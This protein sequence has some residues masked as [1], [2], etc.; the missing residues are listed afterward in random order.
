MNFIEVLKELMLENEVDLK[1]LAKQTDMNLGSLYYY[2]KHNSLPDL[3]CAKKISQYFGCSLDYLFG[4]SENKNIGTIPNRTFIENYEFLLKQ[5]K[6]NN[7]KVCN[8]LGIN[9][10]SIY[11]WKKNK[12]PKTYNLI[13]IAE[14]FDVSV[15][16][17]LGR[18]EY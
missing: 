10:N 16:Y 14:Y 15:D 4:L 13:A 17:L 11:N 8:D 9:R 5:H 1:E 7:Y 2:F 6:T 18:S 12:I 3:N